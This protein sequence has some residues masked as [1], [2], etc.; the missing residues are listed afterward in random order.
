MALVLPLLLLLVGGIIDWGR[1]MFTQAQVTNAAREG[2]RALSL[3]YAIGADASP[4]AGTANARIQASLWAVQ[5][6]ATPTFL[7]TGSSA[8]A[9]SGASTTACAGSSPVGDGARV[10]IVVSDF[11]WIVL[12][13][14]MKLVGGA[15]VSTKPNARAESACLGS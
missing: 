2:A 5:G 10:T 14:A 1:F 8:G 15:G 9:I 4:A 12:D 11:K 7:K 13:P 3:G 6:T